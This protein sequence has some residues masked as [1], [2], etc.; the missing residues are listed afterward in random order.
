MISDP[1]CPIVAS[2][3]AGP[4]DAHREANLRLDEAAIAT[5]VLESGG[6]VVPG[7]LDES[8]MLARIT[9]TDESTRMPPAHF[10]K[11]LSE[12]ET[13]KIRL[14]ISQGANFARHWSYVKPE[15]SPV[16]EAT[17]DF[18]KWPK[19][20][21]DNFALHK[22]IEL[23]LQPSP[24][25]DGLSLIRRVYLDLIGM[26]PTPEEGDE[27]NKNSRQTARSNRQVYSELI[28][29][30]SAPEFGEHWARKWLDLARYAGFLG[31]CQRPCQNNL[32]LA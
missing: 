25:A 12:A 31:I 18:A 10:G 29:I 14:W 9:S 19:N 24:E 13:Q 26:P 23:K 16:P 2:P 5:K 1:S 3:V 7:N 15:R 32:A 27:W 4:D 6:A 21:I 8:E 28:N 20:A 30:L 22:M 11:P 17:G